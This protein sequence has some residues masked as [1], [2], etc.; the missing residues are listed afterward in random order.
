[1]GKPEGK[2]PLGRPRCRWVDNIKMGLIEIGLDRMDWF[3]LTQ[4]RVQWRALVNTVMNLRFHKMLGISW[5][6]A[7]LAAS[8]ERLSSMSEWVS[9]WVSDFLKHRALSVCLAHVTLIHD[10]H[11]LS[12]SFLK[13]DLTGALLNLFNLNFSFQKLFNLCV[14]EVL[15]SHCS[16]LNS[17]VPSA[18]RA[19]SS[20]ALIKGTFVRATSA[21]QL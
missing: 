8:Q 11:S 20:C 17:C 5:A 19:K 12:S 7:Q 10:S 21:S 13:A 4:D 9:E 18:P 1:V 16:H 2:R 14:L 6:A 3:D 15:N